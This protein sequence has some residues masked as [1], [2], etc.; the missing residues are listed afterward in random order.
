MVFQFIGAKWATGT[1]Q[2]PQ[3]SRNL[4]AGI[5][6]KRNPEYL[7]RIA[8]NAAPYERRP[9]NAGDVFYQVRKFVVRKITKRSD[10]DVVE[11]D[12]ECIKRSWQSHEP[13][14]I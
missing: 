9:I 2:L 7:N 12:A 8:G 3:S 1:S 5:R 11:V 10:T 14:I 6:Q 4:A 13:T